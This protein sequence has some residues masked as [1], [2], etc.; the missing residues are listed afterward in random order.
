M[1]LDGLC[2]LSGIVWPVSRVH[3]DIFRTTSL[4]REEG[5]QTRKQ[6]E[7]KGCQMVYIKTYLC[8]CSKGVCVVVLYCYRKAFSS[9]NVMFFCDTKT[10][11]KKFESK[12][13]QENSHLTVEVA[14]CFRRKGV[15]WTIIRVTRIC[16]R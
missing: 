15:A 10:G 4:E 13:K 2:C 14:I 6:N 8:V 1:C 7:K 16:K 11:Y 12:V 5:F 3:N 9:N